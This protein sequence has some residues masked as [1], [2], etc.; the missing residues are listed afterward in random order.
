MFTGFLLCNPENGLDVYQDKACKMRFDQGSETITQN[1]VLS[2]LL[3]RSNKVNYFYFIYDSCHSE[4]IFSQ[5]Q[6][7]F[8]LL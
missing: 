4:Q 7:I 8:K 3:N 2:K 1:I 5:T 6:E